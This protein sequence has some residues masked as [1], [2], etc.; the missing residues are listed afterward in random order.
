MAD[1]AVNSL[2]QLLENLSEII[3]PAQV[4]RPRRA[5]SAEQQLIEAVT[6]LQGNSPD[7]G[8]GRQRV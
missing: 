4:V 3:Y 5:E 2:N 1:K 8:C 6:P 7:R